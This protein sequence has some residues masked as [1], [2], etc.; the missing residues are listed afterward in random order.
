MNE[1]Y[2]LTMWI[3][4]CI[5]IKPLK[6][7]LMEFPPCYHIG[8]INLVKYIEG[9]MSTSVVTTLLLR[10][11]KSCWN[12]TINLAHMCSSNF[13]NQIYNQTLQI[14]FPW[15]SLLFK[16]QPIRKGSL[17]HIQVLLSKENKKK[18]YS[19]STSTKNDKGRN[20][21]F[22]EQTLLKKPRDQPQQKFLT[23]INNRDSSREQTAKSYCGAQHT[24]NSFQFI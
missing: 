5:S 18:D 3:V 24:T 14:F 16:W 10:G 15:K 21:S 19:T 9:K 17:S 20:K 11:L 4:W 2:T 7:K 13:Q 8:F 12:E 23:W 22:P 1:L 6:K